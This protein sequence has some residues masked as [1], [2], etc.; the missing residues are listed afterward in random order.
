MQMIEETIA[1]MRTVRGGAGPETVVLLH[2]T[3]P[4]H[5]AY[6]GGAHVWQRTLS[7]LSRDRH[8]VAIDLPGCG[9][10]MIEAHEFNIEAMA[11][12]ITAAIDALG[13]GPCHLVGHD[14]GGLIALT[15]ALEAADKVRSVTVV[16]GRSAA[17][18]GDGVSNLT[19]SQ[20]PQPLWSRASQA[21]VLERLSYSRHHLDDFIY[22]SAICGEGAAHRAAA[23]LVR[24]GAYRTSYAPS[25]AKAKI[26]VFAA[27]RE[28]RLGTPVQV[29]WGSHDPMTRVEEGFAL[30]KILAGQQP[31]CQ[32]HIVNR[33]GSLPFHE[34]PETFGMI[35]SAFQD[36]VSA[37]RH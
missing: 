17:P 1:V 31:R 35:V 2:G 22:R 18:T 29:V 27:A 4:G 15:V 13:R 6:C 24:S 8:V 9:G 12:R 7:V 20:T 11:R 36:G 19:L 34:E 14:E 5:S 33:A 23:E 16:A 32:F 26:A 28:G 10:S 25:A 30:F 21:F 37:E 3:V